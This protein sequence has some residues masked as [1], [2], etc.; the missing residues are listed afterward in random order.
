MESNTANIPNTTDLSAQIHDLVQKT[1]QYAQTGP[2]ITYCDVRGVIGESN[3][4]SMS[5]SEGKTDSTNGIGIGIRVLAD[6]AWG[7]TSST[8]LD[9]AKLKGKVDQAL[10]IALGLSHAKKDKATVR[11]LDPVIRSHKTKYK[12]NPLEVDMKEKHEILTHM[13]DC[14]EHEEII[15]NQARISA[16]QTSKW[17]ANTEGSLIET[18]ATKTIISLS[19]VS[20]RDGKTSMNYDVKAGIAGFEFIKNLD[21]EKFAK[22]IYTKAV[23]FLDAK[24]FKGGA[25]DVVLSP[26]VGGTLV[27]EVFGHAAEADWVTNGRSLLKD[28][29]N[30]PIGSEM[31]TICDD[32]S[33][34]NSWGSIY[35]DDEGIQNKNQVLV[36]NGMLKGYMH[37][38]ETAC[39]MGVP[40]TGN[41][42]AQDYNHRV[43]PRMTNTYLKKGDFEVDEMI[44]GIKNGIIVDKYT[45]ALEDPAGGS[46]ELK[47]LGGYVIKNGKTETP[48]ARTTLSSP[49]FI[50]TF[51]NIDALSKNMSKDNIGMCGKGHEDWVPVGNPSPFIRIRNLIVNGGDS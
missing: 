28:K 22:G 19:A 18:Q 20:H 39:K 42:R 25:M 32:G 34:S 14:C 44:E 41:G 51:N 17:F 2:Q 8:Q 10:K 6:G 21:I 37:S 49:S 16:G 35:F 1:A 26:S 7:Y 33:M 9:A 3:T 23:D 45:C 46:F 27:H 29:L 38:R 4:L 47:T 11:E 43:I 13:F 24:P 15:H 40:E 31:V 30:T 36:E 12:I 50:D 48:I 5:D